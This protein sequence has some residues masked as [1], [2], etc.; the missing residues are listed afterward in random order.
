MASVDGATDW[1][2]L[3]AGPRI[4]SVPPPSGV[5]NSRIAQA[6]S[7]VVSSAS[8]GR[9]VNPDAAVRA[10]LNAAIIDGLIIGAIVGGLTG[11][12]GA[13]RF[14]GDAILLVFAGQFVYFFALEMGTG[15]TLG[16]R[17]M[18]VRVV[19]LDGSAV[20]MR[21]CAVRNVLR[22]IDVLPLYYASGLLSLITTGRSRRQRIGDVAA[23]TTVVVTGDGRQIR[24][25][26]WLLPVCALT[27]TVVSAGW[28]AVTFH[29]TGE[30]APPS[31]TVAT[32]FAGDSSQA[33]AFGTWQALGTVTSAR[34]NAGSFPGQEMTRLWEIARVCHAGACGIWLTRQVAGAPPLTALLTRQAD[35]WHAR[36]PDRA[37][38]CTQPGGQTV[39]GV[40]KSDWVLTFTAEGSIAQAHE[41]NVYT[42]G[43]GWGADALD[44]TAKLLK[45]P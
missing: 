7:P 4:D 38:T 25:P 28:I 11:L 34:G 32:G 2:E 16:K 17:F 14:S 24:T 10:R 31:Q 37:Y 33:P 36:F 41:R 45:T 15:Q 8:P 39:T 22:F 44:W 1:P 40:L 29:G 12:L 35:G 5:E 23:G 30:A 42:P 20:T 9:P 43:C 26:R 27:A 6:L 21:M 19:A 13:A 3:P 18:N